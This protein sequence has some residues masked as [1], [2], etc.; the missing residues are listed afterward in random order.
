MVEK[1]ASRIYMYMDVLYIPIKVVKYD[2]RSIPLDNT[3]PQ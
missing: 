1:A 2:M 3:V